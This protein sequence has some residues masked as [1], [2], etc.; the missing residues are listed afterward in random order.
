MKGV[1]RYRPMKASQ[2]P[3][4]DL[5]LVLSA[6]GKPP[7]EPLESVSLRL[8]SWKMVLLVI[9]AAKKCLQMGPNRSSVTLRPN[10]FFQPNGLSGGHLNRPLDLSAFIPSLGADAVG[11]TP[12]VLCPVRE[13]GGL[14]CTDTSDQAD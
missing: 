10:P 11:D 13:P 14:C 6:L 3:I 4:W 12:H 8:L 1:R 7:F 2:V 9:T 5:G